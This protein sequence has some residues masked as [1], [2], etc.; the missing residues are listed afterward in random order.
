MGNARNIRLASLSSVVLVL[1]LVLRPAP[2]TAQGTLTASF[3]TTQAGGN[4]APKNIV[5]AWIED[6]NGG[7]FKTIGRWAGTRIDHLVAWT[8]ASGQDVDAVSGA[9]RASHANRLTVTWDMTDTANTLVPDGNYVLRLELADRNSTAP[10]QNNQASFSFAKDGQPNSQTVAGGGFL[11]VSMSVA[12]ADPEL[13]GNGA[14]E[15]GETCDPIGSCP[16]SC[17]PA[18]DECISTAL[19]GSA[20]T[21]TAECVGT[22]ITMCVD[23]DGCCADGCTLA[24]DDDCTGGGSGAAD[25]PLPVTGTCAAN[26]KHGRTTLVLVLL[27]V[28]VISRRRD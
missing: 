8:A 5:A 24:T 26:G 6:A 10:D 22:P 19:A 3:D 16:T 11:N 1:V 21:C 23:G 28:I 12:Y 14:I 13:C 15:A 18:Q 20:A 17:E 4:Y 2:A 7:F 9:T 27:C 25:D